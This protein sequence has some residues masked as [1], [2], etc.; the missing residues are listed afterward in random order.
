MPPLAVAL[1][2]TAALV[3]QAPLDGEHPSLE[4]PVRVTADGIPIDLSDGAGHAGP[5]FA[6]V[7]GDERPDLVVGD[8]RGR[9]VVYENVGERTAPR[10]VARGPLA[11]EGK[12][13]QVHNW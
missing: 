8:L 11:A 3:W 6:D 13:I 9:L 7:L 2:C 4:A 1:T 5:L 10:F 12:P